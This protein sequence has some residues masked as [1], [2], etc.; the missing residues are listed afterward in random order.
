MPTFPFSIFRWGCRALTTRWMF[1]LKAFSNFSPPPTTPRLCGTLSR[2]ASNPPSPIFSRLSLGCW[3]L[4]SSTARVYILFFS[5]LPVLR[6]YGLQL[7]PI[8]SQ[9]SHQLTGSFNS[10]VVLVFSSFYGSSL[11]LIFKKST[12]VLHLLCPFLNAPWR[13][14]CINPSNMPP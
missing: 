3:A 10:H 14:Y 12:V 4:D 7:P 13:K 1:Q 5:L 6:D 8:R 11:K 2:R 9:S